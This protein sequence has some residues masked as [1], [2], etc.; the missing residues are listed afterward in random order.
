[1]YALEMF[2]PTMFTVVVSVTYTCICL[3]VALELFPSV[4]RD[5]SQ[6]VWDTDISEFPSL[7]IFW[8]FWFSVLDF[9]GLSRFKID[10]W[11]FEK[12]ENIRTSVLTTFFEGIL[13]I[14]M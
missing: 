2:I 6:L 9:T 10:V 8:E 5:C 12:V 14:F 4:M 1:M 13:Q 3:C 11:N 7:L